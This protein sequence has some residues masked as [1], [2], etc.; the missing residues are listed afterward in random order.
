MF[1]SKVGMLGPLYTSAQI[2]SLNYELQLPLFDILILGGD[3]LSF[4]PKYL[5]APP[6]FKLSIV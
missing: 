5:R 2:E 3:K 6:I 1:L 4:K